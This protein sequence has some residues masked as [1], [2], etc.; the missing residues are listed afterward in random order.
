ML[1][2]PSYKPD[3]VQYHLF[4]FATIG[5]VLV[6]KGYLMRNCIVSLQ[7]MVADGYFVCVPAR[8]FYYLFWPAKAGP[9]VQHTYD[10]RGSTKVLCICAK[11]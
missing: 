10:T 11:G 6:F 5:I 2:K 8:I 4:L 9:G 1:L 3:V 7:A